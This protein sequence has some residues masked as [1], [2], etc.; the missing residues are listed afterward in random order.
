M[1]QNITLTTLNYE[2]ESRFETDKREKGKNWMFSNGFT[3]FAGAQKVRQISLIEKSNFFVGVK[4][5]M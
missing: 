5:K 4:K 3:F 2:T 1:L